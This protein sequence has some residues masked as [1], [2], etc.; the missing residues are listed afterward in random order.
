M[1]REDRKTIK[2]HQRKRRN[3][4]IR[5]LLLSIL[6]I[7]LG[8]VMIYIYTNISKDY[9]NKY[10]EKADLDYKVKLKENEFYNEEYLDKKIH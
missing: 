5:L 10:I 1:S 3:K 4:K 9:Y 6:F 2:E 8:I 7:T